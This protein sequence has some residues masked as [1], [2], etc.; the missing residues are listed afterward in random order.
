MPVTMSTNYKDAIIQYN[1]ATTEVILVIHILL[2]K[3]Y[4]VHGTQDLAGM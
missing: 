4:Y 1:M 3:L 2:L